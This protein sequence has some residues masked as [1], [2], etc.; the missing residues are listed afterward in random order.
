MSKFTL[1]FVYKK[2]IV[3][4]EYN[5]LKYLQSYL[6]QKNETKQKPSFL[7]KLQCFNVN[8]NVNDLIYKD[9]SLKYEKNMLYFYNCLQ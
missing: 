7:F 4:F 1:V 5:L 8:V 9:K 6:I 3:I 2:T